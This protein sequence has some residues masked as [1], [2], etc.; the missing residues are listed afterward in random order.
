M[1]R[2]SWILVAL[3]VLLGS[4]SAPAGAQILSLGSSNTATAPPTRIVVRDSLGLTGKGHVSGGAGVAQC[5]TFAI[6]AV[7][8]EHSTICAFNQPLDLRRPVSKHA[9]R[10]LCKA[11][12][13]FAA[14]RRSR[15]AQESA[16]SRE[17][18]WNPPQTSP[19]TN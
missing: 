18:R 11:K 17:C 12:A 19:A 6:D 16:D 4:I 13:A 8:Q 15:L 5:P 14:G 2:A 7:I 9:G 10:I 1:K 3:I